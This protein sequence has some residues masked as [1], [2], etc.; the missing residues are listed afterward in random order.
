M[1]FLVTIII[2]IVIFGLS[3][4]FLRNLFS[5]AKEI[6]YELDLRT[7]QQLENLLSQGQKVAVAFNRRTI[8]QGESGL[9]G[10][11]IYNIA[12]REGLFKV[13][14]SSGKDPASGQEVIPV[15]NIL[16]NN[17]LQIKNNDQ[18]ST[19]ILVIVPE[20]TRRGT[21]VHDVVVK[22][23]IPNSADIPCDAQQPVY[24]WIKIYTEV[25]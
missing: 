12:G 5:G 8:S 16:Y 11:G 17:E 2:T 7:Q 20:G 4:I 23:I 15:S 6:S 10:L 22:C 18:D 14:V 1:G 19:G 9:F 13:N 24:G 21:Y 25:N 3:V